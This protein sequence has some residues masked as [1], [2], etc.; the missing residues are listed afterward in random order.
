MHEDVGMWTNEGVQDTYTDMCQLITENYGAVANSELFDMVS[1][2]YENHIENI[3]RLRGMDE[4]LYRQPYYFSRT[5]RRRSYGGM[6]F[7]TFFTNSITEAQKTWIKNNGTGQLEPHTKN[8][9]LLS[10]LSS[11]KVSSSKSVPIERE[12]EGQRGGHCLPP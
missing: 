6:Y 9:H 2:F 1:D 10:K 3:V 12:A 5:L 7:N 8:L 4:R 11:S